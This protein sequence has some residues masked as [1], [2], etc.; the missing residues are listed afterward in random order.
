MQP[1]YCYLAENFESSVPMPG[2]YGA[3]VPAGERRMLLSQSCETEDSHLLEF[4]YDD[5]RT[6]YI[7]PAKVHILPEGAE[8]IQMTARG[9]YILFESAS[10]PYRDTA[11]IPND[12]IYL[13]G[14]Y[15]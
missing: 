6:E 10:R 11:R 15:I 4:L 7:E 2:L 9:M 12:Q 14:E 3:D 8:Q 1:E 5:Q 13:I